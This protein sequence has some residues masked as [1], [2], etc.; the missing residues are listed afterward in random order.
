MA[1]EVPVLNG[2]RVV[3]M[4]M[5]VAGPSAGGIMA[6]WGA[7][8]V[9]VE[10]PT[11]DP[12]RNVFKLTGYPEGLPNPPFAMD[13]RGKRSV[14][15]D[16]RSESGRAAMERLLEGADVFLSNM[17]QAA[18][19]RLGLDHVAV[20]ERHPK[21]IYATVSGYGL[22][23]P[24]ADRPGYDIGAF[25]ARTG[26]ARDLVPR[27]AEP[28]PVRAGLGDHVTGITTVSGILAA[29][30]ERTQTGKGRVVEVSLLRTG[31]YTIGADIGIHATFGKLE[32]TKPRER[33][34]MP[35]FNSYRAG[36]GKWF[37]L[38]GVEADRHF[39]GLMRA[40]G[41]EDLIDDERF[42]DAKTR[43][44]NCAEFIAA[45]DTCFAGRELR[46]WS[47]RFDAEDV[48]W[49]PCQSIAEVMEDAQIQAA[50]GFVTIPASDGADEMRS[51]A[52]P[53]TFRGDPLR[54][55][56]PVPELGEH[57]VEVLREAGLSD[58]EIASL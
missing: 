7:D 15:L 35:M 45:L 6:D 25:W 4:T 55:T 54:T 13:N 18:L 53:V 46:E 33:S 2:V 40:I 23:G 38:L 48:W 42:I 51:V 57:T 22:D 39:P 24:D 41:R 52:S 29:L 3:E 32:S 14:A 43:R 58:D 44:K 30:H 1:S 26:I 47:E 12:Q 16:L 50:G 27:D 37:W 31:M 21:L 11:G 49:A 17:R 56:G 19:R 34:P 9:K 10:P 36:D 5:W 8:V 28:V 20:S